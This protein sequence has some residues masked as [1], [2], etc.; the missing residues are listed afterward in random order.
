MS[1]S[2]ASMPARGNRAGIFHVG[3]RLSENADLVEGKTQ[4]VGQIGTHVRR[5]G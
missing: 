5:L 3:P 2:E 1:Q 4:L